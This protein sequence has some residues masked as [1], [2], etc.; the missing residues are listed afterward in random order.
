MLTLVTAVLIAPLAASAQSSQTQSAPTQPHPSA[1]EKPDWG[2]ISDGFAKSMTQF[3]QGWAKAG[4]AWTN[5]MPKMMEAMKQQCVNCHAVKDQMYRDLAE[6]FA[7]NF[8]D[9]M[10]TIEGHRNPGEQPSVEKKPQ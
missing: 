9:Y 1:M 10:K 6:R 4:Q 3:M 2:K 5:E 8:S 7:K